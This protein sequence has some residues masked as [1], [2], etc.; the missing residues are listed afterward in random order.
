MSTSQQERG[1]EYASTPMFVDNSVMAK[2]K[3]VGIQEGSSGVAV[4]GATLESTPAQPE[5]DS[6]TSDGDG[7]AAAEGIVNDK[8]DHSAVPNTHRDDS[9]DSAA[10]T[11]DTVAPTTQHDDKAASPATTCTG[12]GRNNAICDEDVGKVETVGEDKE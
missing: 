1:Y 3:P 5:H 10:A 6:T 12:M 8:R 7:N 9:G 11:D 4:E 2:E